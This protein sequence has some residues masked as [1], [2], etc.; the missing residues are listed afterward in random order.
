VRVLGAVVR[1]GASA[2]PALIA[3]LSSHKAYVRHGSALALAHIGGEVAIESIV[4]L[5][6]SEPTE[7]WRE[8]AR[9]VGHAG[10]PAIMPLASRLSRASG[11]E[12]DAVAERI[13]WALAHVA[14]RGQRAAV[15]TLANGQNPRVSA[16]ARQAL[17]LLPNATRDDLQVRGTT[18][19]RDQ[20]VNRAFSRRFFEALERGESILANPELVSDGVDIS[21]PAMLLDEADLMAIEGEGDDDGAELDES[22]LLPS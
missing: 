22:D 18:T 2:I 5:L 7:I 20:T 13:A 17:E 6:L 10:A 12:H 14:A 16:V 19:P 1:F 9:A 3:N 21:G 8:L 15:E 4:D 11:E